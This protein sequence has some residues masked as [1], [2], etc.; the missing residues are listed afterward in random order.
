METFQKSV[1]VAAVVILILALSF[2]GIALKYS[3]QHLWPPIIPSCPDYWT[4][5]GSGND[6]K[7]SNIKDLGS[8]PANDGDH[9]VMNFNNAPYIGEQAT[10]AKY[11]WAN[12]CNVSW[13]GITYGAQNPCSS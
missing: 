4:I 7:C 8:C 9:L 13:D 1:L 10:C 6:T 2:I 3:N 12:N 5:D 11:T